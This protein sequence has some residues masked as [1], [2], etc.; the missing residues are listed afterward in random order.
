VKSV[1]RFEFGFRT[2]FAS[3]VNFVYVDL[4]AKALTIKCYVRR[5]I[6]IRY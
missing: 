5:M 1:A 3:F 2:A 4:S 6:S